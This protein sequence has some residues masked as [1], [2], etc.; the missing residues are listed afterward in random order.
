MQPEAVRALLEAV[1]RGETSTDA[2]MESLRRLPFESIDFA[3]IDHHRALR[4]G[5]PEVIYCQGK[6]P[7]QVVEIFD[8]MVS[9]GADVL[10]TRVNSEHAQSLRA[11]FDRAVHEEVARCAWMKQ[12]PERLTEGTIALVAAGTSDLPVLEEAR[13]T[14]QLFGQR[15][16]V[17]NDVGVAGLHRVLASLETLQ[18]AR[19]IVAVA[20]MEGALPG[21]LKGLVRAPVIAVPTSVGYGANFGGIAPLLTMLNACSSGVAVVNIDNGFAAGYLASLIN[22]IG[23]RE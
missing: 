16:T 2:A 11:K 12:S 5:F 13:V 9:A 6:T 7:V 15:V 23:E 17:L 20:G 21:V 22:M 19:V 3:R 4:C 14:C 1:R 10:A 18:A 8:K